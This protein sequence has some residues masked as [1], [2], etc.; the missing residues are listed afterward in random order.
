MTLT[1][2]GLVVICRLTV[3]PERGHQ[4]QWLEGDSV[5]R[6]RQ[7]K[8]GCVS[9]TDVDTVTHCKVQGESIRDWR[10]HLDTGAGEAVETGALTG[11]LVSW[12]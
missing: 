9:G 2:A 3:T 7:S 5:W 6:H 8:W 12:Y 10:C 4:G 1:G 11:K